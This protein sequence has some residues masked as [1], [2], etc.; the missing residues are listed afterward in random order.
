MYLRKI[1]ITSFLN[2]FSKDYRRIDGILGSSQTCISERNAKDKSPASSERGS[3]E[4]EVVLSKIS[5]LF[6][7]F[8]KCI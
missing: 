4:E 6:A 2:Y 7:I 8:H 5:V 1:C 3:N